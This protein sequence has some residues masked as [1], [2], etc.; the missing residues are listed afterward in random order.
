M[1]SGRPLRPSHNDQHVAH[2]AAAELGQH[3]R[4][5]LGAFAAITGPQ[6]QDVAF[7]VDGD[8]EGEMRRDLP[9][10]QILRGERDHQ[11]IDPCQAALAL[12]DD[13][14]VEARLAVTGDL[15]LD[16]PS[17]GDH[18][19][20]SVPVTRVATVAAGRVAGLIADMVDHL[21]LQRGLLPARVDPTSD[22][23]EA[24]G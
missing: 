11:V 7:P 21:A 3:V 18:R 13:L 4:P 2:A 19:L 16:R 6:P 17:L 5:V 23:L 1:A 14:R 12:R 22:W 8:G 15:D 24:F 10:G 20:G 9:M